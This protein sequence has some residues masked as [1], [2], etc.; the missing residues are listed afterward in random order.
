VDINDDLHLNTPKHR[1]PGPHSASP[2]RRQ[3]V[4]TTPGSEVGIVCYFIIIPNIS[5]FVDK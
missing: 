5:E 2:N 1:S 4:R 3:N